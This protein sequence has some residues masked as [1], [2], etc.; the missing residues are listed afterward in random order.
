[1]E[2][3]NLCVLRKETITYDSV[4]S[5]S[6]HLFA[7]LKCNQLGVDTKILRRC[8]GTPGVAYRRVSK[9]LEFKFV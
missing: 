6:K 8:K 5:G 4:I 1:M 7:Q 3:L 9:F 2:L